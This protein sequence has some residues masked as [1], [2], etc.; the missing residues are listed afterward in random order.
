MISATPMNIAFLSTYPP[1]ECGLA[2]FTQDLVMQLSKMHLTS[3]SRIIAVSNKTFQYDDRVMLE[4]AQNNRDNYRKMAEKLNHSKIELLVIEH[5]YG[6]YG[7]EWGEYLL[8]LGQQ[9]ENSLCDDAAYG[10]SPAKHKAA[11]YSECSWKKGRKSRYH[12]E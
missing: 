11:A 8:D 5:E 6:I 9:P 12:G 2:T 10:A 1:R 4:L 7:G 3:Q